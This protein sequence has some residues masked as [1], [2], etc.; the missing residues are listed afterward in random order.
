M[1]S[2][3]KPE[4]PRKP[5]HDSPP[6]SVGS[7]PLKSKPQPKIETHTTD[8]FEFT[9]NSGILFLFFFPS[10][11]YLCLQFCANLFIPATPWKFTVKARNTLEKGTR[12]DISRVRMLFREN[13]R[14]R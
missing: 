1:V 4:K 8:E 2:Y 7:I 13:F 6:A 5:E 14:I 10:S 11:K 12:V 3:K 9:I